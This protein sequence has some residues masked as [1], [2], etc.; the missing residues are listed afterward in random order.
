MIYVS[1]DDPREEL[2]V[3]VRLAD[4]RRR[5]TMVMIPLALAKALSDLRECDDIR[6]F[7]GSQKAPLTSLVLRCKRPFDHTGM[8]S[9]GF[10][11]W[12]RFP[13]SL[14]LGLR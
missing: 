7:T 9:N 13:R 5:D 14:T 1:S 2:G 6:T 10:T 4:S 8:H 11:I 12:S 3:R